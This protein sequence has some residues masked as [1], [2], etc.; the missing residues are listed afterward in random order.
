MVFIDSIPILFSGFGYKT[1]FVNVDHRSRV[2]GIQKYGTFNLYLEVYV[3][4]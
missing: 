1:Y 2:F 3:K 4:Y